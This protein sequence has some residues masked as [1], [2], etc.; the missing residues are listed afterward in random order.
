[1]ATDYDAPRRD[2]VE[3]GEDS[4]EELKLRRADTQSGSVDI[5]ET[6][7]AEGFEL[8][9]ADLA[10]EELTVKVLPMQTDEFGV[11]GVFSCTTAASSP[12]NATVISSVRNAHNRPKL[13]RPLTGRLVPAR[14]RVRHNRLWRPTRARKAKP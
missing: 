9:G 12:T 10:D 3:L 7:V 4:I 13:A 6:E 2:E 1:M 14:G 11:R 8:P 5:D